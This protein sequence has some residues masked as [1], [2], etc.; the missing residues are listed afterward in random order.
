MLGIGW[1]TCCVRLKPSSCPRHSTRR[2]ECIVS[3]KAAI[4]FDGRV[5]DG[6]DDYGGIHMGNMKT[7]F[8]HLPVE[9]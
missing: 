2:N 9:E 3:L 5:C 1:G 8:D 6:L 7:V 4:C